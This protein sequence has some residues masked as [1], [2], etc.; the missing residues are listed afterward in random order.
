MV[1]MRVGV[2]ATMAGRGVG[3]GVGVVTANLKELVDFPPIMNAMDYLAL[4]PAQ[5]RA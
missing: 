2:A 4:K 5:Y 1:G 3:W